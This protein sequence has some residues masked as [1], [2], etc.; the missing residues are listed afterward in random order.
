MNWRH[1]PILIVATLLTF[2]LHEGA[3][4]AA[5]EALGY[6]MWVNLNSAGLA[7]GQYSVDWHTH[8][9]SAAGPIITVLQALIGFLLVRK[10]QWFGAFAFV[11]SALIMR[12]VAMLMSANNPNDEA[13]ISAWLGLGTWTLHIAVVAV[14]LVLTLKAGAKLKLGWRSY[15]FAYFIVSIALAAIILGEPYVP[16]FNPY[17]G[18]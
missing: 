10:F 15:I 2:I 18:R 14:L 17:N 3:H 4:F 11:F 7:R 5:G 1:I 13:R 16:A 12:I 8:F 9:V 6:D